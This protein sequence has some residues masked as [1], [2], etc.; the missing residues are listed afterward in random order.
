MSQDGPPGKVRCP[1][2]GV[3]YRPSEAEGCY[4]CL[5]E[6]PGA[7]RA[8][9]TEES[10]SSG[11]GGIRVMPVVW[12]AILGVL[13]WGGYQ[14]LQKMGDRG[15]EIFEETKATAGRIDPELVRR[16]IEALELVVYD[17]AGWDYGA[18]VNRQ[19]AQLFAGVTRKA[20]HLLAARHGA[21]ISRLGQ[22]LM[23]RQDPENTPSLDEVDVLRREWEGVRDAVFNDATWYRSIR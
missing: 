14:V 9:S 10:A 19:A 17:N 20:S 6:G 21:V 18:R 15:G 5:E 23:S 22:D 3:F 4:K 8:G 16:E 11:G 2:H 7:A 13:G 12:I 1:K